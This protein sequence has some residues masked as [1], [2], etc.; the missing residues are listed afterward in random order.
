VPSGDPGR[1][2]R[3]QSESSPWSSLLNGE[4]IE[5]YFEGASYPPPDAQRAARVA[6]AV[7]R[8]NEP[9]RESMRYVMTSRHEDEQTGVRALSVCPAAVTPVLI[10]VSVA[11]GH[12]V[13]PLIRD[14]RSFAINGVSIDDRFVIRKFPGAYQEAPSDDGPLDALALRALIT[15]APALA[16]AKLVFDCELV[17]HFDLEADHEMY[18]GLVLDAWSTASLQH[19][20]TP[21]GDP[22]PSPGISPPWR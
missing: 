8:L 14:S 12:A 20:G 22:D 21:L 5:P 18:I 13:A 19:D 4:G 6:R 9:A 2:G 16:R 3:E 1:P 17:H 10:A 15:G 7:A 11:K